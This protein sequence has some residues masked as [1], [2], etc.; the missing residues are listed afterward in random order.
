[1]QDGGGAKPADPK[2][3]EMILNGLRAIIAMYP[4]GQ[5]MCPSPMPACG[6][7]PPLP[8]PAEVMENAKKAVEHGKPEGIPP[9]VPLGK[10]GDLTTRDSMCLRYPNFCVLLPAPPAKFFAAFTEPFPCFLLT[11]PMFQIVEAAKAAS[12]STFGKSVI[13]SLQN[14]QSVSFRTVTI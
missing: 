14:L 12:P 3:V 2:E 8:D 9:C 11:R 1:M 7:Y 10:P 4:G 13:S 5:Q 6:T